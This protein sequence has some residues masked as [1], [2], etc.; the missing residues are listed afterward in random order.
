MIEPDLAMA[1]SGTE[2]AIC[3]AQDLDAPDRTRDSS[4]P[5]TGA[6]PRERK[7]GHECEFVERPPKQFQ[8]ECSICLLI[9]RVPHLISCCGQSFCEACIGRIRED[10]KPCPLCIKQARLHD[11]T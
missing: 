1:F 3:Q 10:G 9:L 8:S 11:P 5:V 6:V 7:V 4:D 2:G